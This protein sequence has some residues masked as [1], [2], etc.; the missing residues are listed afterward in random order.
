MERGGRGGKQGSGKQHGRIRT[1]PC[2]MSD[3]TIQCASPFNLI[4]IA[5]EIERER[6]RANW[7][8][9]EAAGWYT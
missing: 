5:R 4:W 2:D 3:K 6:C 1:T 9:I 8:Q 7:C